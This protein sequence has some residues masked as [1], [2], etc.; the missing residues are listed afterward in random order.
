MKISFKASCADQPFTMHSGGC[1]NWLYCGGRGMLLRRIKA[2]VIIQHV[3]CNEAWSPSREHG[4]LLIF[5][6]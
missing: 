4:G 6:N 3:G 2:R 1:S 5:Q